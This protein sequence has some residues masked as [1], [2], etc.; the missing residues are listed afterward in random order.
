MN[1][2]QLINRDQPYFPL[3]TPA[4]LEAK[5][6]FQAGC[7][8][9]PLLP[10]CACWGT[11]NNMEIRMALA[12]NKGTEFGPENVRDARSRFVYLSYLD[13][14]KWIQYDI[15]HVYLYIYV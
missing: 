2:D 13:L 10:I 11:P 5:I 1:H 3:K 7:E 4:T 12:N 14:Y 6:L 8:A 15:Y 9:S